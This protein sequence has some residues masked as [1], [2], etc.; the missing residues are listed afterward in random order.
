MI[1]R[2]ELAG[3]DIAGVLRKPLGQETILGELRRIGY[4]VPSAQRSNGIK[5]S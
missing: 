2:S 4:K 1:I 5:R 3:M